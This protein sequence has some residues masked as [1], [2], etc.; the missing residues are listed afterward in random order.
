MN[1]KHA[2]FRNPWAE[3]YDVAITEISKTRIG[4]SIVYGDITVKQE[5]E[6]V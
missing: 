4:N 1:A 2:V 6:S 5:A 3:I